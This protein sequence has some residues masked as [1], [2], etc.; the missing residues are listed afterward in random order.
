M[1]AIDR[2][3]DIGV[4]S[5]RATLS[6]ANSGRVALIPADTTRARAAFLGLRG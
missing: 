4:A 6:M 3:R 2:R 5:V 1:S